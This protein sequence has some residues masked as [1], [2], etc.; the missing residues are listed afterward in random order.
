MKSSSSGN[1]WYY[2]EQLKL[3]YDLGIVFYRFSPVIPTIISLCWNLCHNGIIPSNWL[4]TV[5]GS[6]V[7]SNSNTFAIPVSCCWFGSL[8]PAITSSR[9][10]GGEKTKKPSLVVLNL[11]YIDCHGSHCCR[12]VPSLP[13]TG[14]GIVVWCAFPLRKVANFVRKGGKY[15]LFPQEKWILIW[16]KWSLGTHAQTRVFDV[17]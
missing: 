9:Q 12:S 7:S 11:K 13:C 3:L 1:S 14:I 5:L 6:Y 15:L 16:I 8:I 2:I 4:K 10:E 17:T